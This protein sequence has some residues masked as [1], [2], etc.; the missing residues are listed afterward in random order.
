MPKI[1]LIVLAT[2]CTFAFA[3]DVEKGDLEV[4]VKGG[5]SKFPSRVSERAR[6]ADGLPHP[7][8]CFNATPE[9][10]SRELAVEL[11]AGAYSAAPADCYRATPSDLSPELSVRLCKNAESAEPANCFMNTPK[12]L[13]RDLSVTL[14]AY[15]D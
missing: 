3:R 13:S 7:M 2:L 5:I 10:L 4:P 9:E 6:P 15:R 1:S 14:C 11:C 8:L 12:D